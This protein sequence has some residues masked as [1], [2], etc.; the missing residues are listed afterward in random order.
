[1]LM[2]GEIRAF[3]HVFSVAHLFPRV[4]IYIFFFFSSFKIKKKK[5]GRNVYTATENG[6]VGIFE[7]GVC[8]LDFWAAFDSLG[9]VTNTAHFF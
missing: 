8:A 7:V 1:M 2:F 9:L 5:K 6:F 4:Y 3:T